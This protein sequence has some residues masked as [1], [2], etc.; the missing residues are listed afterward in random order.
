MTGSLGTVGFPVGPYQDVLMVSLKEVP[1]NAWGGALPPV[2]PDHAFWASSLDA[3]ALVAAGQ[4]EYAPPGT[5][6]PPPEPRWTVRGQPGFAAG[7]SNSS[8]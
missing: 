5:V 6:A 8:H 4:A 3:P 1:Q 2:P 7:T